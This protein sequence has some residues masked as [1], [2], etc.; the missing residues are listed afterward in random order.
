[1]RELCFPAARLAMDAAGPMPTDRLAA[2][3]RST[4]A[5]VRCGDLLLER[6]APGEAAAYRRSFV[7][8]TASASDEATREAFHRAYPLD[9][10]LEVALAAEIAN[11]Q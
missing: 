7:P 11:L 8:A 10:G 2:S 9:A 5:A 4:R 6:V 3:A 1:V